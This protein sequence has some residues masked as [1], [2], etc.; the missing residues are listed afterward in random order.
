MNT[1]RDT[2]GFGAAFGWPTDTNP[3]PIGNMTWAGVIC[4][5]GQVVVLNLVCGATLL[6]EPIPPILGNLT[7]LTSLDLRNC[8]LTGPIP[9]AIN[10][11]VQLTRLRLMGNSLSGPIPGFL[12]T[13]PTLG[14]PDLTNNQL[15]GAI[16]AFPNTAAIITRLGG[17]FLTEIPA[18]WTSFN[19][20]VSYN[21]Y[22]SLPA[23]CDSQSATN[24]C[25][26][27]R[28]DCPGAVTLAKVSG[29]GQRAQ[30]GTSFANPLVVLVSDLSSNP[31]AGAL[32]TFSGP[33]IVTTTAVSDSNGMAS[34]SVT[35]DSTVGGN[36]VTASTGPTV[37][38]AFGLTNGSAP[39]CSASV[40]VTSNGDSGPGT[41]RQALADVCPGGTVNLSAI[42]GQTVTLASRL[43]IS[44]DV[45][46]VGSGVTISGNGA[47]RIFFVEGGNVTL[48]N[49][50]LENGLGQGG[51]AQFGGSAAGMG[52][53]I[54]QNGGT[55]TLNSVALSGN[56]AS[57]GSPDTSGTATG[58]GFGANSTGGDLGG[59]AGT[60]DG[61]G[62]V[63]DAIGGI[64]GF[65]G[66]GGAGTS[67]T[68]GSGLIAYGGG[69]GFGGGGGWSTNTS[70]T[71]VASG[72]AG[73]GGGRGSSG[74]GGGGA[75]F[76]GAIFVRSGTLN[77]GGVTFTGNSAVGGSGA[78]G[79]GGALFLY[80][81]AILNEAPNLTFTGSV[82][83]AAGA[84]GQ[85]YSAAPYQNG[86]TCP[87]VDT[88]DICGTLPTNTLTV[89]LSGNGS[90]ADTA[91]L[92]NCPAVTCSALFQ[93]TVVLTATPTA[94]NVF[95][96]WSGGGC[97]GTGPCTVSL[98]SGS[99]SVTANFI[100]GTAPLVT[101]NPSSVTVNAGTTATFTA[102]ATGNPTPTVQWQVSTDGVHFSNA[103]GSS[104][105]TTYSFTAAL[106][107]NGNQYR[108]VFTNTVTSA[109]S[110]AATLY[111]TPS[112]TNVTSTNANG[113]Y[114]VGASVA[115]TVAFT[116]PVTVTGTPQLALNSGGTASYAGG[117]GTSTLTFNCLV[118]APQSSA[119]LEYTSTG[120]LTLNGGSIAN[121]VSYAALLTLPAPGATGSLSANTN[122]VI[123][124]TPPTVTS[125]S[126]LFGSQSFVVGSVT[127][128]DLPW[129][130]TGIKVGFSKAVNAT[131]A[132]LTGVTATAVAGSGTSTVTWTISPLTVASASTAV[133]G[134]GA[135]AVKDIAGNALGGGADYAQ[136]LQVL[137]G[138]YNGDGVVSAADMVLVNAQIA[139]PY[140]RFADMNGD[141]VVNTADVTI[142]RQRVG[143]QL[144]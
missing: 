30:T 128:T 63:T 116:S 114:G 140:N 9:D 78:Q 26:P 85:G 134:T 106:A 1:L 4:D 15:T 77:L 47:T 112:V 6:N 53:A 68:I 59:T 70:A 141:G 2:Y 46:I 72:I 81:G 43:Y 49:L 138:D 86:A 92:I 61:A 54:F 7:A 91:N 34:A 142:V 50:T 123:D 79:K 139:Q 87:G 105:S 58:G 121:A 99:V 119:H 23:T 44:T 102:A 45:T 115:I 82:A 51:T 3:C 122:I 88:V 144:P 13:F 108:A 104:T 22:P 42:A 136:A 117:S 24:A 41:L 80:N 95:S 16:P 18:T 130:I 19:R 35:A 126:V 67:D 75:G 55:L 113:S 107:M 90:V 60:G 127:R 96:S 31:V 14:V 133:K 28:Q 10:N 93:G 64:G 125:Y 38:V 131:M 37:M 27:N 94:G 118:A 129:Q 8:G 11:L 97:S 39:T 100:P 36:T 76:G 89:S 48:Q 69:G 74:S 32:V 124:T 137:W 111:I 12:A 65:G 33:G 101:Q 66:G 21:C 17:N 120:A 71:S 57:G 73:Y 103:P 25:T 29:D 143:T 83:A 62:G 84:A 40:A 52:G 135:S 98:A 5:Q 56:Q 132:S 20:N 109:N 110:T